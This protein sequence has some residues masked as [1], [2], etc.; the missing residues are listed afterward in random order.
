MALLKSEVGIDRKGQFQDQRH[1][2]QCKVGPREFAFA[3]QDME[4]GEDSITQDPGLIQVSESRNDLRQVM[5]WL[6][7]DAD[8]ARQQI[9]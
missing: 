9:I 7:S 3:A 1:D 5:L 4:Q 6:G 8:R 2:S